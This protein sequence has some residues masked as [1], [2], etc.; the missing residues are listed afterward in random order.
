[1]FLVKI[2]ETVNLLQAFT[3]AT[4]KPLREARAMWR[5]IPFSL[6][7]KNGIIVMTSYNKIDWAAWKWNVLDC[8]PVST[9]LK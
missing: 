5:K 1:M 6:N 3:D 8:N 7:E 9:A 4:G 2:N